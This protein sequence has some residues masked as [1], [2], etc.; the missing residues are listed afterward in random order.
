M[1]FHSKHALALGMFLGLAGGAAI[2]MTA[3]SF[4]L[5]CEVSV[6]YIGKEF[7]AYPGRPAAGRV[8]DIQRTMDLRGRGRIKGSKLVCEISFQ[9]SPI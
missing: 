1:T 5:P 8:I 9:R 2:L 4:E 3:P 7:R 6:S